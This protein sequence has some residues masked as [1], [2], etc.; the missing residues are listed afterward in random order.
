MDPNELGLPK[1]IMSEIKLAEKRLAYK[2]IL[3]VV[4]FFSEKM[5]KSLEGTHLL[6]VVSDEN[7][8]LLNTHGDEIIKSNMAQAGINPGIQFNEDDMGTNVV[9]LTLQQNHPIQLLGSNHYH[10]ALHNNA[11]YGVPF[12]YI[13][14]DDLLGSYMYY[15]CLKTSKSIFFNHINYC[16]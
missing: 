15:D 14:V 16:S 9:S 7:G 11:C 13:D 5:L 10:T 3:E 12:H 6:I 4:K 8:Y 1:N 2:E